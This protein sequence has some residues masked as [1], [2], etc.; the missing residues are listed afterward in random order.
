MEKQR[1]DKEWQHFC[2]TGR[3]EDYLSY[4][5]SVKEQDERQDGTGSRSD[6]NGFKHH[7]H[8]GI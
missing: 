3:V 8:I 1:P 2:T 6:G 5:N 7:A 4:K